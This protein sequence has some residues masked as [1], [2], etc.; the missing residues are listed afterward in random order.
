MATNKSSIQEERIQNVC[1]PRAR[2][3][4]G[5]TTIPR[6]DV[7]AGAAL[8]LLGSAS[9]CSTGT[10][11]T[12][13]NPQ[14]LRTQFMADFTAKFIGDPTAI[15]PPGQTDPWPDPNRLWPTPSGETQIQIVND[16]ATFANVLMTVG[17]VMAPPP[18]FP[19]G[20]LGDRIVQFLQ[21]ENWPTK[22]TILP[23]N[24]TISLPSVH[25]YEIGVILDRLLQAINSYNP[26]GPPGG[27]GSSW[28]PH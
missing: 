4:A 8:V 13:T 7:L 12:G 28:P 16:Y 5:N 1:A 20:T 25:L 27:G 23:P 22:T 2:L 3:G 11:G 15:K 19:A 14:P 21:A 9:G 17:Y 24:P 6:R 10:P 26:G 18:T